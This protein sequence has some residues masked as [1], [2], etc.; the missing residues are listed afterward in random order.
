[1]G[2]VRRAEQREPPTHARRDGEAPPEAG[3]GTQ[4]SERPSEREALVKIV[5]AQL[6]DVRAFSRGRTRHPLGETQVAAIQLQC[7]MVEQRVPEPKR[8][9]KAH[10][11]RPWVT[12]ARFVEPAAKRM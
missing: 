2:R 5:G 9:P 12:A 11:V 8:R 4:G 1:M 10:W 7:P 3:G 6:P